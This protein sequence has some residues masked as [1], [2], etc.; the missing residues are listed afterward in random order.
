MNICVV[1]FIPLGAIFVYRNVMQGCGYG[2]L[3]MAGG[4]RRA[5]GKAGDGGLCHENG[6]LRSYML[7]PSGG[8]DGSGGVFVGLL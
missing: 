2:F 5:A 1:F 7:L 6:K 8:M 3:P 4:D